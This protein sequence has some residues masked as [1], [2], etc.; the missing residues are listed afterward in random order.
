MAIIKKSPPTTGFADSTFSGLNA[1]YLVDGA[2][3]RTPVRWSFVP[4]QSASPGSGHGDDALF[5]ALVRQFRGGPPALAAAPDHRRAGRPPSPTRPC[6]GPRN[7]R[8]INAGTLTLTTIATEEAGNARD[9]NFDP[10]VLP[11]GI[12]PSE[13]PL[14]SGADRRC[15]RRRTGLRTGEPKSPSAVQVDAVSS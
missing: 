11:D 8:V 13:D 4:A 9:V 5:D 2:G 14:L 3:H 1:F 12:E 7:R 6:R 10:L 15:T